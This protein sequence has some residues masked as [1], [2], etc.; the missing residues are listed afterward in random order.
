MVLHVQI[1]EIS[2]GVGG[3]QVYLTQNA[4]STDFYLFYYY[5]I[6]SP[7]L[8]VQ[9]GPMFF[10][11]YFKENY[12]FPRFQRESTFSRGSNFFQVGGGGVGS[13]C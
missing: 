3:V 2:S 10:M 9:R 7:Q 4:L 13:S 12:N 11:L 6:F 1:Q 5:Y 8:I